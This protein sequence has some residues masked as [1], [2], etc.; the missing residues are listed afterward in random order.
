[1]VRKNLKYKITGIKE[2]NL[3][4]LDFHSETG[5]IVAVSGISGSGKSTLVNQVIANEANRQ[6]YIRRKTDDIYYYSVRPS[7]KKAT[8]IPEPITVSQRAVFQSSKSTFGTK[9]GINKLI[10]DIFVKR[11][12]ITHNG[13]LIVKPSVS[14]IVEF[15]DK[16]CP[17]SKFLGRVSNYENI[18]PSKTTN[19]L[20]KLGVAYLF[21]RN[22]GKREIRKVSVNKLPTSRWDSYEVFIDL[23][24]FEDLEVVLKK[25]NLTPFIIDESIELNCSENGFSLDDGSVFRLPS[26]L[27]FSRSTM[28]SLSGCCSRCG[29]TGSYVTYDCLS[30]IDK[31]L[32]IEKGF[33]NVP[34]TASGRYRAFKYLPSGLA[35]V[36]KKQGVDTRKSFSQL[37]L[38]QQDLVVKT[39]NE[40]LSNNRNDPYS[41]NYYNEVECE[42]CHGS[43]L[44]SDARHVKVNGKSIDSFFSLTA[45]GLFSEISKIDSDEIVKKLVVILSYLS[46]LSIDHISFNR[47]TS[48][49]SSG[50]LQ[51]LKL[52]MVVLKNYSHR[53]VVI[54]EPSS[55][56][57]YK[58]NLKIIDIVNGLKARNNS[59]IIVDHSPI[60]ASIADKN[61]K[62]GP[63]SGDSGGEYCEIDRIEKIVSSFKVPNKS[64]FPAKPPSFKTVSLPK[65]RN[66]ALKKVK[67]AEGVI[68]AVIGASGSGKSTLCRDLIYPALLNNEKAILFDSKPARGA[69]NSIVAT[70]LNVF[71]KIRKFYS[72]SVG[73][74]LNAGDFS[75]NSTGACEHCSGRGHVGEH[76]CGVCLGSRF[77]PES[78]LFQIEG[79]SVTDLLRSD[80]KKIP[81]DG[82]YSFLSDVIQVLTKLSLSHISLGRET[83]SLSG[84]ELQRLKLARFML[85]NIN[86]DSSEKYYVILDEPCRGLDPDSIGCLYEALNH[87]LRDATLIVIEHNPHFIY[88]CQYVI[89]MGDAQGIKNQKTVKQGRIDEN[90]FPSLNHY[91]LMSDLIGD[92]TPPTD[93][94]EVVA[95]DIDLGESR[96][97]CGKKLDLVPSLLLNQKNFSLE[98][99]YSKKF[100]VDYDGGSSYF[101]RNKSALERSL[102]GFDEFFYNPF[103]VFLEKFS[104]VPESIFKDVFKGVDKGAIACSD[105][106]WKF[107]VKANSFEEA[108]VKGGGCVIVFDNNEYQ[109]HAIR[110]I[111]I[112]RFV[113]D[114]VFPNNYAFNLYKNSCDYCGGYGYI[115][116]YPFSKWIKRSLSIFD[117]SFVPLPIKKIIP[118][119]A[120]KR[121]AKEKLFDFSLPYNKLSTEETNILLYGFKAYRFRKSGKMD[122]NESSYIEWKGLNSYI[123]RNAAKLSPKKDINSLLQ[124][125]VC[126]FCSNGLSKKSDNYRIDNVP[127]SD[128]LD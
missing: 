17:D 28:S 24:I 75:F 79:M 93:F 107:K 112:D 97:I 94:G 89:D 34:L 115:K 113:V 125:E 36:L 20:K 25:I 126:P 5:E 22:E 19:L 109:Y 98:E 35:N 73:S 1:M 104:R 118:K 69:S 99:K 47:S 55:N 88:K 49:M 68:T 122:D 76:I 51:R 6:S 92:S 114:K 70:Y 59:V 127:F 60:Y 11:G 54:D 12:E 50:E 3:K 120:V 82:S 96:D 16:Y 29:G 100:V 86:N 40:K 43:G 27:L 83:S 53:V 52:L 21:V 111:D 117:D 85:S 63:G 116:S 48:T 121:F 102:S 66:V 26:R 87:Y 106:V 56:L 45:S 78:A 39:L 95:T 119:V 4:N 124:L 42:E 71:D 101:Y 65:I 30:A 14:E 15:R 41:A 62:V 7:F 72:S 46:K 32:V 123:Y 31:K 90:K 44:S 108:Y 33:L 8:K 64:N 2:N 91:N 38:D 128:F 80:L 77:K 105:D 37:S 18:N 58:D 57:Q 110:F 67:I 23:N 61:I 13:K 81:L 103:F 84:G 9:T 74:D 10:V